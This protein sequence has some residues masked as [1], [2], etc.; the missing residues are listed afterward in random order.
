MAYGA[1]LSCHRL[2]LVFPENP[3]FSVTN[4]VLTKLPFKFTVKAKYAIICMLFYIL[5][6]LMA[7]SDITGVQ[8]FTFCIKRFRSYGTNTH[9]WPTH[10]KTILKNMDAFSIITLKYTS[11][12]VLFDLNT[13]IVFG[14]Y[15]KTCR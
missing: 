15:K 13:N 4:N 12:W 10:R 11:G 5:R 9:K 2:K 14:H 7:T 6:K 8:N 1:A 3:E